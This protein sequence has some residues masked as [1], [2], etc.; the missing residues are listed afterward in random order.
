LSPC[1]QSCPEYTTLAFQ[2]EKDGWVH[3]EVLDALGQQVAT[4]ADQHYS[5]GRHVIDLNCAAFHAGLYHIKL[6]III[7][8][9]PA[10]EQ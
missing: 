6:I 5:S 3:I 8:A 2:I 1:G 7:K 10:P 9:L 4:L